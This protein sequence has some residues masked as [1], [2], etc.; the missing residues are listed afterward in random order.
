MESADE[1]GK[2]NP[3]QLKKISIKNIVENKPSKLFRV[4]K[5]KV[6][7]VRLWQNNATLIIC[8]LVNLLNNKLLSWLESIRP[9]AIMANIHPYCFSVTLNNSINKCGEPARYAYKPA[10]AMD[11][12][13]AYVQN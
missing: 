13:K 2:V 3:W 7:P 1:F 4:A 6:M 11:P 5:N 8:S 12:V 10:A 9:S